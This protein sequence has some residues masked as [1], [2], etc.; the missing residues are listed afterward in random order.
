MAALWLCTSN[1]LGQPDNDAFSNRFALAGT[2]VVFDAYLVGATM[3]PG[4]PDPSQPLART[5]ASAWWTWTAPASGVLEIA[6]MNNGNATVGVAL[7]HGSVVNDLTRMIDWKV[8]AG[9]VY[10]I[11]GYQPFLV[12]GVGGLRTFQLILLPP[13]PNDFFTNSILLEGTNPQF[14]GYTRGATREPGEKARGAH[15]LWWHWRAPADGVAQFKT[16][17]DDY[18]GA[19]IGVFQGDAVDSLAPVPYVSGNATFD[20]KAGELYRLAVAGNTE[21][22]NFRFHGQLIL[23]PL[24]IESPLSGTVYP[25]ATDVVVSLSSALPASAYGSVWIST[26]NGYPRIERWGFV[27]EM[28]F[29]NLPAGMYSIRASAWDSTGFTNYVSPAVV[30]RVLLPND[31]FA[32]STVLEGTNA[33]AS[34]DMRHATVEPGEIDTNGSVWWRWTAPEGGWAILSSFYGNTPQ[35][36]VFRGEQLRALTLVPH[37]PEL[38]GLGTFGFPIEKGG[39]YHFR[40][41]GDALPSYPS[42]FFRLTLAQAPPN[43]DFANR[44]QLSDDR[45]S[46]GGLLILATQ[47]AGDPAQINNSDFA[48]IWYSW[49]APAAGI[50][51]SRIIHGNDSR[52]G[53]AIFSGDSLSTLRFLGPS[54]QVQPGQTY[55]IALFG[56]RYF[57]EPISAELSF[58]PP[59][60][61]DLFQNA[62]V[63]PGSEGE[64]VGQ[65]VAATGESVIWDGQ[66]K[67]VWYQW[68][69]PSNGMLSLATLQPPQGRC[70]NPNI[71]VYLGTNLDSLARVDYRVVFTAAGSNG[72]PGWWT[73]QYDV[74]AGTNYHIVVFSEPYVSDPFTLRYQFFPAP[75]NDVFANRTV[76]QGTR[77]VW[78]G[79]NQSASHEEGE[80]VTSQPDPG[81]SLWYQW[82]A[83]TNGWGWLHISRVSTNFLPLIRVYEGSAL[84]NLSPPQGLFTSGPDELWFQAKAGR[85]YVLLVDNGGSGES[86]GEFTAELQLTTAQVVLADQDPDFTA[87]RQV[88][89]DLTRTSPDLD[90]ELVGVQFY[91]QSYSNVLGTAVALPFQ[92][93]TPMLQAGRY[94]VLAL[95]TNSAGEIRPCV[96]CDFALALGNDLFAR[97][98]LLQ[99]RTIVV[100][101]TVAGAGEEPG[102][103]EQTGFTNA[104]SVWYTWAAQADGKAALNAASPTEPWWTYFGLGVYT[105]DSLGRL[106]PVPLQIVDRGGAFFEALRGQ[107]YQIA[108]NGFTDDAFVLSLRQTTMTFSSPASGTVFTEGEPIRLEVATTEPPGELAAVDFLLGDQVLGSVSAPPYR[109]T[110][111]NAPQGEMSVAARGWLTSGGSNG[112]TTQVYIG[113]IP[114][115]DTFAARLPVSGTN[116]HLRG[117]SAFARLLPGEPANNSVWFGWTAP[118]NGLLHLAPPTNQY[119]PRISVFTNNAAGDLISVAINVDNWNVT[120][121][122]AF[123]VRDGVSYYIAVQHSGDFDLLLTFDP[124]P[125]ND[126]F[127]HRTLLVGTDVQLASPIALATAESGEPPYPDFY[128]D[129]PVHSL[130]W[131][132]TAPARGSIFLTN[133]FG[134]PENYYRL[135]YGFYTGTSLTNLVPLTSLSRSLA[136]PAFPV[137]AGESYHLAINAPNDSIQAFTAQFVFV[138]TPA[139]DQFTNRQTIVGRRLNALGSTLG[140]TAEPGEPANIYNPAEHSV[141]YSWTAPFTGTVYY[142]YGSGFPFSL[143]TFAGTNLSTLTPATRPPDTL[144]FYASQG[145]TY[146]I[147]LDS[148]DWAPGAFE[149][150]LLLRHNTAPPNDQFANRIAL[151][152]GTAPTE[153]WNQL[154][155]REWHEPNHAGHW[156][157]RS[158]WYSWTPAVSGP[159]V[160]RVNADD[161][162]LLIGVYE[163]KD[164][165]ALVPVAA[166]AFSSQTGILRFSVQQGHEYAIALDGELGASTEFEIRVDLAT[167]DLPPFLELVQAQPDQWNV[168]VR[169]LVGRKVRLES[170]TNLQTWEPQASSAGGTDD[171]QWPVSSSPRQ[172]QQGRFFR[173]VI[174]P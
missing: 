104:F 165:A 169:N 17:R 97:R 157:G 168:V 86:G 28:V 54:A 29:S 173:A 146:A 129:N 65:D 4:E 19:V 132:W 118:W 112:P 67:T 90:G 52:D 7:Y 61:N 160:V 126:D 151:T 35:I 71:A 82:T 51:Y 46:L 167:A 74:R 13:P 125:T 103:P 159:A 113:V 170:S 153:G 9:E 119:S 120:S 10:Q 23:S 122:L 73:A 142:G 59:P 2:N 89:L 6:A 145:T 50:L 135:D 83:P 95:T 5:Q 101:G 93:Q 148:M 117:N 171:W 48:S 16:S 81:R 127:A 79:S 130:W 75:T 80:P 32:N 20:V 110:W 163:G 116:T 156:G 136:L 149:F 62:Q 31:D 56:N 158:V 154:A 78:S 25:S 107:I 43:D 57:T 33:V 131:T 85:N 124:S 49:T 105:G 55:Q 26:S 12:P 115:N 37:R 94:R 27:P 133:L 36:Q 166:Y 114:K 147:A 108:V 111:S 58:F 8:K 21:Q 30:F 137:Q 100:E 39:I 11:E 162:P 64:V 99:G 144:G 15:T 138:P 70:C 66:Y 47:Q 121:P 22:D 60:A 40:A 123:M 45:N 152:E 140:A 68:T 96:P 3:E 109:F 128:N 102:E 161:Y 24:R 76:L 42:D 1:L 88:R 53:V 14:E 34:G 84:T 164:V 150:S 72:E 139:N 106:Q 41:T 44:I 92:V 98:Q 87:P 174:L 141:W 18:Y 63:L 143:A 69:A 172:D 77:S 155:T 38:P 91:L 134:G